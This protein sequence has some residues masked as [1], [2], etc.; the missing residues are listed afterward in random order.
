MAMLGQSR[1]DIEPNPNEEDVEEVVEAVVIGGKKWI[2]KE[3]QR[4]VSARIIQAQTLLLG[5]IKKPNF[6]G[7]VVAYFNQNGPKDNQHILHICAIADGFGA[8]H[9]SINGRVFCEK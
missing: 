4:L 8:S 1:M 7:Q 5:L 3:N 9:S 6:W 2:V